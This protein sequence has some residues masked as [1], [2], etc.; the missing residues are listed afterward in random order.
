[1]AVEV[2]L[3]AKGIVIENQTPAKQTVTVL[4]RGETKVTWDVAVE[5]VPNAELV[6]AAVSK[7]GQY[8]DASKPRLTTGPDGSL[9]VLRYNRAGYCRHGRSDSQSRQS[10]RSG[11]FAPKF[12]DRRGELSIQLD[13][14]LA[15]GMRDGL[16][17]LEHYPY[18]CTEQP[19]AGFCPTC[20]PI[21]LLQIAGR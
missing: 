18:E 12:D 20:S 19:S 3:A 7:D 5:D 8:N 2:T 21:T 9:L 10:Q 4:A 13:P 17:Y 11:S 6:F 14:S 16:K 1:M 15:A